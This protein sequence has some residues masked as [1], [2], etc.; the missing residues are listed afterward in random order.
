[1]KKRTPFVIGAIVAL[2]LG[3]GTGTAFA[4]FTSHGAGSG[5]GGAGTLQA[6]TVVASTGTPTAPLLPG[7]AGDVLLKVNNPNTFAVTLVSVSG[8]G[9]ITASGGIGT[10]TTTGVSFA[11][12]TGLAINIPGGATTNV[13]LPAAASMSVA[14]SNGCQGASFSIPVSISVHEG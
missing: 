8:D 12:Q 4:Y 3:L 14:S 6:V 7:N 5:P 1:M 2:V 10:C 11:N 13:D 9:M